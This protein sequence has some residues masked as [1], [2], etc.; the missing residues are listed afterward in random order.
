MQ[1]LLTY[2]SGEQGTLILAVLVMAGVQWVKKTWDI[3]PG[4]AAQRKQ[5]VAAVLAAVS[6]LLVAWQAGTLSPL[7]A[8]RVL[9]TLAL[10]TLLHAYV[11][12]VRS[13]ASRRPGR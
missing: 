1:E 6:S 7:V 3:G 9:E 2:L 12:G 10:A 4:T 8:W 11:P 13:L 5:L